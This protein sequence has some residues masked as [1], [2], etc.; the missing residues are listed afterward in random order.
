MAREILEQLF[1]TY[2]RITA[3]DLDHNFEHMRKAW[4]LQQ[5]VETLLKQ[6]QDCADF[7]EAVGVTI[8]HATQI[9]VGYANIFATCN[10]M[11]AS[12]M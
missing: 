3:V 7:S 12:R 10:F 4:D 1:L 2:S 11:S 9:N 6:I 5:P 8:Y